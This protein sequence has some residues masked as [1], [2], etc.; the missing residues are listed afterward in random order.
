MPERFKN[1]PLVE[2]V[3]ELRW[4][5]GGII[6]GPGGTGQVVMVTAGQYEEF[7][8]R[9]GSKIATLGYERIEKII[10]LDFR[11]HPS[12][13]HTGFARKSLSKALLSTR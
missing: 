2:L 11:L 12:R 4:G 13:R 3:A 1:P 8:M 5:S 9:F 6:A 10:P 7:F